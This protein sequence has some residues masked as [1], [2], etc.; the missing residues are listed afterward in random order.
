MK[1]NSSG[2][3]VDVYLDR[4]LHVCNIVCKY[5]FWVVCIATW[6]RFDI[7]YICIYIYAF[8]LLMYIFL[9]VMLAPQSI[10]LCHVGFT[11]PHIYTYIFSSF[12]I[13]FDT[14]LS[15]CVQ[16]RHFTMLWFNTLWCLYYPH[17]SI[18]AVSPAVGKYG[19]QCFFLYIYDTGL[20]WFIL[21]WWLSL[22]SLYHFTLMYTMYTSFESK[23]MLSYPILQVW[24]LIWDHSFSNSL[25]CTLLHL[26]VL[27]ILLQ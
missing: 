25:P 24:I 8:W 20:V 6:F 4:M 3:I 10:H 15:I 18:V 2:N 13:F 12:F 22:Y 23:W 9:W 19:I 27:W 5:L 11:C 26:T 14:L 16:T 1:L 21:V 17:Y 7:Y